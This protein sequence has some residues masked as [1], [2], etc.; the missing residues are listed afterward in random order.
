MSLH[1]TSFNFFVEEMTT[2]N[3]ETVQSMD[4]VL[5]KRHSLNESLKKYK[6]IQVIGMTLQTKKKVS[7]TTIGFHHIT[8]QKI[9]RDEGSSRITFN[10]PSV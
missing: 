4:N 5:N 9:V 6:Q 10:Q 2:F 3:V 8:C 1:V 7:L